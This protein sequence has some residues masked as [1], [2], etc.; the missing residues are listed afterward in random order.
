MAVISNIYLEKNTKNIN[1]PQINA[2]VRSL[3]FKIFHNLVDVVMADPPWNIHME[4]PYGTLQDH[5]MR[6][7]PWEDIHDNGVLFL[8]VFFFL[9]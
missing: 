7:L 5:E 9:Y 1:N 6:S 2:D 8:W 4:L 3:N